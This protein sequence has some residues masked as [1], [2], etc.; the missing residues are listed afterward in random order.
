MTGPD[1]IVEIDGVA[2]PQGGRE[3]VSATRGRGRPW[4]AV[5]WRCCSVYN[6]VYRNQTATAYEGACPRCGR[7]VR[8]AI[9]LGGTDA[10]FFEAH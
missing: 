9:G 4:L 7:T 5:M 3:Q 2:T 6:R 1:Y 10:R 8:V